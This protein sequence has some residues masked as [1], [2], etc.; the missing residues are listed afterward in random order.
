MADAVNK[1]FLHENFRLFHLRDSLA[2][3]VE[4]H[5]H[6]FDKIVAVWSGQVE[7][8]VEGVCYSLGPGDILFVRHNDI[9]RPV[10]SPEVAYERTVLWIAPEYLASLSTAQTG[11]EQC[12]EF[13]SAQRNCLYR[14][15]PETLRAL[16]KNLQALEGAIKDTA[17]GSELLS[18]SLFMQLMV[19]CN[20]LVLTGRPQGARS[21]DPK[22]EEALTYISLHLDQPLNVDTIA[23]R[24]YM[25][26]YHFMRRF[27]E[28]TGYTVH[29]YVQQKRLLSVVEKLEEGT[30]VCQAA[31]ECGFTEYSSFLRAFRKTFR[32]TPT[33]YLRAKH[34]LDSDFTE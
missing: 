25:S 31:A 10:I 11:L 30:G 15:E 6:S 21:V 33:D 19:A 13:A 9:H 18:V 28:A 20:R 16:R 32:L 22:I 5:Y 29:G 8:T 1:G 24:C 26:R 7:Y 34:Q 4:P 17:F 3:A 23:A 2:H 12:F 27:K 14:P